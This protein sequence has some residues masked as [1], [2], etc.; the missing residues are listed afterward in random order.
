MHDAK[1]LDAPYKSGPSK[2]WLQP[3]SRTIELLI[4]MY[5]RHGLP[6]ADDRR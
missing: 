2:A 6:P 4:R 3:I 1:K 5:T